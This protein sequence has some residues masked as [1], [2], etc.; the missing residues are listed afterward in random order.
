[1][2]GR[3]T[4]DSVP[5]MSP[6]TAPFD[7]SAWRVPHPDPFVCDIRVT[8]S[9]LSRTIEHVS[10]IEYVRWLDRAAELHADH[11]GYT[12]ST[13]L[14]DG[15]MWFVARHEVDYL[16][17]TFLDDDL[18][19]ATWVRNVKKVKTWRDYVIV[20]PIDGVVICRAATLWV[21]VDLATRK[22]LRM[23][24]EMITRFQPLEP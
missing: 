7:L 17:E 3:A 13:L 19:V 20:R 10:N 6:R 1:M 22:P 23:T 16:A 2:T 14:N 9:Q 24:T 11:V 8:A 18:V 21:L 15:I 5:L 4:V 12:R